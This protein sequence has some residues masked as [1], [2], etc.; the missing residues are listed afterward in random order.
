MKKLN[1]VKA[2]EKTKW[3]FLSSKD[4]VLWNTKTNELVYFNDEPWNEN[5]AHWDIQSLPFIASD[6]VMSHSKAC[7]TLVRIKK[8]YK[9]NLEYYNNIEIKK[10][11]LTFEKCF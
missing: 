3:D 7:E 1:E 4:S 8:F 9:K 10:V 6:A 2:K 11:K 5:V